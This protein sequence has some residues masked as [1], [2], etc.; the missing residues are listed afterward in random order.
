MPKI[1]VS[2]AS[3]TYQAKDAL[4]PPSLATLDM[5]G[6]PLRIDR[7]LVTGFPGNIPTSDYAS[8]T[9]NEWTDGG[10]VDAHVYTGFT[11][12]YY[13]KRFGRRGLNNN[14]TPVTSFT[15]L[16]KREDLTRNLA[17]YGTDILDFYINAFYLHPLSLIHISEPT[18]PY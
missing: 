11:Y 2:N 6:D 9:D 5:K 18:R 10:V 13:F 15:N 7:I 4:R 16:V 14:N 17:L 12:D 8:D 1:S 3:G